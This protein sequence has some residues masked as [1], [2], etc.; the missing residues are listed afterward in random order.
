MLKGPK[1]QVRALLMAG[2]MLVSWRLAAQQAPAG[3]PSSQTPIVAPAPSANRP[4]AEHRFFDR[5]NVEL[6]AGVAAVRAL[7]Y[8][9]T[10][11]FRA[12]GVNEELLSNA[13]VD[14]KPLFAGIE[15]AGA[16]ASMAVSY[17]LHR[18]GHHKIERWVSIVHIGVG[19]FGDIRN[20]TLKNSR[21]G[22]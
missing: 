19:G 9:S 16:A 12:R 15:V 11:H 14:N 8:A 10:R 13:I 20:Y 22:P 1:R 2:V 21:P 17:W 5:T 7:D 4:P 3:P 18:T 6:F